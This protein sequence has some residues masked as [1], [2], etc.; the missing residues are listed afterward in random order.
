MGEGA[1]FFTILTQQP[2]VRI[3]DTHRATSS[4]R[5]CTQLGE[6]GSAVEG[7]LS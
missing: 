5:F 7:T 1:A 3:L 2:T 4:L 6:D